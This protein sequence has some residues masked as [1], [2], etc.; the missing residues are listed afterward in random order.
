MFVFVFPGQGSQFPGMGKAL[1]DESKQARSWFEKAN[2]TLGYSLTEVM[3]EGTEE[4]LKQTKYTQVAIYT[5]S[6]I[7]SLC[8]AEFEADAVAGHSLG[9]FSALAAAGAFPFEQGLELVN[10]RALAMQEACEASESTMAA[11][12]GLSDELV[13]DACDEITE[14]VVVAANFNTVGQ[15]VISGSLAGVDLASDKLKELGAKRVV[16]LPVSGAFHSP[17]MESARAALADKIEAT[18]FYRPTCPIY[19]N[20][21]AKPTQD[22]E[23]IQ[24]QLIAQLTSPVLWT[25]SVQ[26]MLGDGASEFLEIGP[27][28][29]L[30]GLIRKVQRSTT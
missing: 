25:Q 13:K 9:E 2:A 3:F 21:T 19:Q 12:L 27:G 8:Q 28:K 17:F 30:T 18:K 5:H 20:V 23:V 7:E 15:V 11:V 6:V 10:A 14:E 24:K 26:Q 1:Y 29:V 16:P 22:P 4:E